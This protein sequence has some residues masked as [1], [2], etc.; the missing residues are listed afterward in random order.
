MKKFVVIDKIGK[1]E[2]HTIH[3]TV[4]RMEVVAESNEREELLQMMKEK[5]GS[6]FGGIEYRNNGEWH[7][8]SVETRARAK[9][10]LRAFGKVGK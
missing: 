8:M 10:Y 5:F 4:E 6:I 1:Y 2:G 9:E 3:C 7:S